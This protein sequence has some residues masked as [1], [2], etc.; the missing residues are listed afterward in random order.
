MLKLNICEL[1]DKSDNNRDNF[2]NSN[3]NSVNSKSCD[4]EIK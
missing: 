4:I 2:L 1:V 3:C